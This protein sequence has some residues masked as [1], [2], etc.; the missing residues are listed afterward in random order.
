MFIQESQGFLSIVEVYFD[1]AG[2]C[3]AMTRYIKK[4]NQNKRLNIFKIRLR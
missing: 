3:H 1:W 4:I 2:P